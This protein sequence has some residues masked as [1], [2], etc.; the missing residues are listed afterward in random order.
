MILAHE[1]EQAADFDAE[2]TILGDVKDC[3][4]S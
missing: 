2:N 1:K 3:K 4:N